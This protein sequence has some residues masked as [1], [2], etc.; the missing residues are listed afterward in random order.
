MHGA[1]GRRW[2]AGAATA[3]KN[4]LANRQVGRIA[5]KTD[6]HAFHGLRKSRALAAVAIV[7]LALSIGA[8]VTVFSVVRG[9]DPRFAGDRVRINSQ[10][11]LCGMLGIRHTLGGSIHKTM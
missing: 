2:T 3:L 7:S 11:E 10:R 1:A 4:A 6:L 8:N 9:D 5:V